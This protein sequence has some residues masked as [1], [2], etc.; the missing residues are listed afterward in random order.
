MRAFIF[1]THPSTKKLIST[2]KTSIYIMPKV[3]SIDLDDVEDLK[4]LKKII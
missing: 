4:I 1:T 3:R 2:N